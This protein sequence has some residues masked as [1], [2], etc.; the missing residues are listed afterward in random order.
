MKGDSK[1]GLLEGQE[2]TAVFTRALRRLPTSFASTGP[3]NKHLMVEQMA[4]AERW[5]T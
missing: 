2:Q 1:T 3:S 5:T 4:D